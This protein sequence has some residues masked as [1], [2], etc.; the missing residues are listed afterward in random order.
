MTVQR[1]DHVGVVV[2]DLAAA[3]AFFVEL[4]LRRQGEGSVGGDWVDRV[5]GLEGVR[6]QIVMLATPDGHNRLELSKFQTP[7]AHNADPHAPAN[8]VGLR[9]LAFAVDDLDAALARLRPHGAEL[10][11][12]VER[13]GDV[14]RLCY[15]RGPEGIIVELAESI[16]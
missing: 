5:V 14:Y 15:V 1:M 8:T 3:T 7:P 12:E 16:G 9:H 10:V 4:G 13:Y 2:E 6:S 11:G